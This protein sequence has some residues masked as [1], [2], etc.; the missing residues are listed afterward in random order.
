MHAAWQSSW[1]IVHNEWNDRGGTLGLAVRTVWFDRRP[2]K[3]ANIEGGDIIEWLAMSAAHSPHYWSYRNP[4]HVST[5]LLPVQRVCMHGIFCMAELQGSWS[6]CLS[7]SDQESKYVELASDHQTITML[8]LANL[9]SVFKAQRFVQAVGLASKPRLIFPSTPSTSHDFDASWSLILIFGRP[10][11]SGRTDLP[12]KDLTNSSCQFACT[13][14]ALVAL[15][16]MLTLATKS[17]PPYSRRCI[18]LYGCSQNM[19]MGSNSLALHWCNSRARTLAT[20]Y[21]ISL[22]CKRSSA[23]ASLP[24]HY[25]SGSASTN[26]LA[27]R[28]F[29]IKANTCSQIR[30]SQWVFTMAESVS[31]YSYAYFDRLWIICDNA[32]TGQQVSSHPFCGSVSGYR[33]D[34][35]GHSKSV[36]SSWSRL[37]QTR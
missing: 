36:Q 28:C 4:R 18:S 29:V 25:R 21:A 3:T 6:A 17:Y 9:V 27:D 12:S 15:M 14:V 23:P 10:H 34:Y 31:Q 20:A 19:R 7:R 13:R 1:T 5:E 16:Q 11:T 2:A 30:D 26:Q 37:V 24:W 32:Q 35:D 8:F 22:D 33:W